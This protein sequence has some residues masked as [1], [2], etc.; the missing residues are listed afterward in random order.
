MEK[1][2]NILINALSR[3]LMKIKIYNKIFKLTINIFNTPAFNLK[4]R[5]VSLLLF[6]EATVIAKHVLKIFIV[7][8][9]ISI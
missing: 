6:D 8:F 1:I 2:K 5:R 9:K 7:L 4:L 3:Y